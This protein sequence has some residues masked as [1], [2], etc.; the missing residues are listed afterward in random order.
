MSNIIQV[1][2]MLAANSLVAMHNRLVF[3]KT[4][5]RQLDAQWGKTFNG[6]RPGASFRINRPARY[7]SNVGNQIGEFNPA[8]GRWDTQSFVEDPIFLT[9]APEQDQLNIPLQFDSSELTLELSNE[10]SRIGEPAGLQL[11]ADIEKKIVA[12]TITRGGQYIVAQGNA[13][14]GTRLG[15]QDLLQGQAR[16]DALGCPIGS[17]RSSLIPPFA[18]AQLSRE[19]LTL[20]TPTV[21]D[22]LYPSGYINKFASADTYSYN[23]LPVYSVPALRGSGSDSDVEY[24][25]QAAVT[26]G[27]SSVSITVPAIDNGKVL[28]AGTMFEFEAFDVVNPETRTSIGRKYSFAL[29][30]AV[31]LATGTIALPIDDGAKIY[32]P[33]DVGNRQNIS[34]LPG[35][36]AIVRVV[37]QTNELF[38]TTNTS[39]SAVISFAGA[40]AN[41]VGSSVYGTGVPAGATVVSAV[42][43][44]SITI[45]AV[46]TANVTAIVLSGAKSYEQVVMYSEEAYT[47]TII[48]LTTELPGAYAA[49][50]DV[51]GFSIR[52]SVQT[53]VGSDTVVHRF[54][55]YGKGVLQRDNYAVRILVPLV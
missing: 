11:A 13:T 20:F 48:P 30:S 16:L 45:S 39:G 14:I 55:V 52:T 42:P 37:G 47:G 36:G 12:E 9:V 6:F 15:V 3:L 5:D 18:M 25:L 34:A 31:T 46:S 21:N 32:G 10:K 54:D 2:Q 27:A 24:L 29:K 26:D 28:P 17:R 19:N 35:I 49:R 43:G 8:T 33:A 23:L 1:N 53:I 44:T 41:M 40:R 4:I 7:K 51:D 50:A 22:K 38:T